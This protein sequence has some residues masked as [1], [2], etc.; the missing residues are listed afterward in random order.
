MQDTIKTYIQNLMNAKNRQRKHLYLFSVLALF[1]TV[2]VFWQ[3]SLT[4]ITITNEACC[5]L[6][7]HEHTEDCI[8]ERILICDLDESTP[9]GHLSS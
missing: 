8:A 4:G 9:G 6:E 1:V 3:L 5:G 2:G 7:E